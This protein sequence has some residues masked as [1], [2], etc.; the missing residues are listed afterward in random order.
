[1]ILNELTFK[2]I[3]SLLN[4]IYISKNNHFPP[5]ETVTSLWDKK[6]TSQTPYYNG[7]DDNPKMRRRSSRLASQLRKPFQWR[8]SAFITFDDEMLKEKEKLEIQNQEKELNKMF[9][10]VNPKFKEVIID[11]EKEIKSTSFEDVLEIK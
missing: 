4:F 10:K 8:R 5:L 9:Q 11:H 1:M 2:L 3:Y 7:D 6:T